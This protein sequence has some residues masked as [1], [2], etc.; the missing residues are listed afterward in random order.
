MS[1][2]YSKSDQTPEWI[3]EKFSTPLPSSDPLDLVIQR[4][5]LGATGKYPSGKLDELDEGELQFAIAADPA[6]KK[7]LINF[8]K[9]VAFIG[10][11]PEQAISL[12][13]LLINKGK[14]LL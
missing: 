6:K 14:E 4:L 2:H 8:G 13:E 7:V 1:H 3:K 11:D 12:G 9:P 10:F 5:K